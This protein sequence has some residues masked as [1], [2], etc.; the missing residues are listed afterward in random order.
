MKEVPNYSNAIQVAEGLARVK[1]FR[2]GWQLWAEIKTRKEITN[3]GR[4]KRCAATGKIIV[5][6]EF[7]YRPMTNGYNRMDR[8]SKEGMKLLEASR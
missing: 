5:K 3:S 2:W 6:G 4:P 1:H 7:V 8:I